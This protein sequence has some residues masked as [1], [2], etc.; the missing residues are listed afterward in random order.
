M[1]AATARPP[2]DPSKKGNDECSSGSTL[3]WGRSLLEFPQQIRPRK[4][5]FRNKGRGSVYAGNVFFK[6]SRFRGFKIRCEKND[7]SPG[8][9]N[10][11][12]GGDGGSGGGVERQKRGANGR[13]AGEQ[14]EEM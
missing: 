3:V 6:E 7:V 5:T 4:K 12:G 9:K 11:G 8:P 13:T 1:A 2:P 14:D 10:G